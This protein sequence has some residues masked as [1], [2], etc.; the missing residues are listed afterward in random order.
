MPIGKG[1]DALREVLG[2]LSIVSVT[3]ETF[4]WSLLIPRLAPCI[5]RRTRSFSQYCL[6]TLELGHIDSLLHIVRL[7]IW[8][9]YL[10][11][12]DMQRRPG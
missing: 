2:G 5:I 10:T 1:L 7:A 8:L 4:K 11:C 9:Q 12:L 3:P 6:A